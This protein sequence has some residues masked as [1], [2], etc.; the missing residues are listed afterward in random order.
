LPVGRFARLVPVALWL[1]VIFYQ[2]SRS[3]LPF[4]PGL[5]DRL[6]SMAGH[7]VEYAVLA[8]LLWWGISHLLANGRIRVLVVLG[9]AL[10]YAISDEWHQSFVPGRT[11]DVWDVVVDMIGAMAGIVVTRRILGKLASR[12]ENARS[13]PRNQ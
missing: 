13:Y 10:V 6:V 7:F 9:V 5:S 12:R 4:P 11:P 3:T 8:G 1:G 2:S